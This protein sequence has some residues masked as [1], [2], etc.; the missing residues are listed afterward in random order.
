MH[1]FCY[2]IFLTKEILNKKCKK[3]NSLLHL[4]HCLVNKECRLDKQMWWSKTTAVKDCRTLSTKTNLLSV[5]VR[6][7]KCLFLFGLKKRTALLSKLIKGQSSEKK[8]QYYNKLLQQ[9][10][11]TIQ[12]K[13]KKFKFQT[14]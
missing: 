11:V 2:H 5:T 3:I 9:I 4:T 1:S 6:L 13:C 12:A 10:T 14:I 7:L 8:I